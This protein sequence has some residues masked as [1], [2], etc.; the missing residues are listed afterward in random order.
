MTPVDEAMGRRLVLTTRSVGDAG[1]DI[2]FLKERGIET[3]AAPMLEMK[4]LNAKLPDAG[5]FGAVVLTS[6]NA[7]SMPGLDAFH[8]L[9][10]YCVGDATARAATDAG[11]T[12][13]QI[14]PGDAEGL[15][16]FIEGDNTGRVLWASGTD[17]AV[18]LKRELAPSGIDVE[19]VSAYRMVPAGDFPTDVE[20]R[21]KGGDVGIVLVYS[22]R[23]GGR[24]RD[25]L[26]QKGLAS[27]REQMELVAISP[28]VAGL[29][30]D[31]WHTITHAERP[32][33]PAMMEAAIRAVERGNN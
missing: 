31:G 28:R 18:D 33:R 20:G 9:D 27:H 32:D 15:V 14:G 3:L 12:N 29:C 13:V 30:G 21:I 25:L 1:S 4:R 22:A 19:Q 2:A 24:F 26:D 17:T 11:F 7:A 5:G 8:D 10:C 16:S 23:A 6:R